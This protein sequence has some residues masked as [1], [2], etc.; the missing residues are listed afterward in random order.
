MA[1]PKLVHGCKHIP[2]AGKVMSAHGDHR[3]LPTVRLLQLLLGVTTRGYLNSEVV[4]QPLFRDGLAQWWCWTVPL[5]DG[6]HAEVPF[7][8]PGSLHKGTDRSWRLGGK[9]SFHGWAERDIRRLNAMPD[10][11]LAL[12]ALS[13]ELL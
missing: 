4:R 13:F 6:H 9:D 2:V 12:S 3:S 10:H 11:G 7:P 5:Q 8:A 1:G